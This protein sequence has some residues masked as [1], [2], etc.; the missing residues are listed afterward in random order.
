M[1]KQSPDGLNEPFSDHCGRLYSP[2]QWNKWE[3]F[4]TGHDVMR[5]H[6]RLAMCLCLVHMSSVF[7]VNLRISEDN[8]SDTTFHKSRRCIQRD[9]LYLVNSCVFCAR[10]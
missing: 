6:A 8:S 4:E 7:A 2:V 10:I 5:V 9:C 3:G 1:L